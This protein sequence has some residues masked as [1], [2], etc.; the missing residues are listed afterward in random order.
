MVPAFRMSATIAPAPTTL[1]GSWGLA[2]AVGGTSI[3]VRI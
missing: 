3:K 1:R 2:A